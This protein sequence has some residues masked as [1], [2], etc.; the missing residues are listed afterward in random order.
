MKEFFKSL[1]VA[2]LVVWLYRMAYRG[3]QKIGGYDIDYDDNVDM[4]T[5]LTILIS[6]IGL[7]LIA[8]S[9]LSSKSSL[10][11]FVLL[12]HLIFIFL[13]VIFYLIKS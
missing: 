2:I 10:I 11:L 1:G 4:N 9:D 7:I 3:F 8:N 5:S 13:G 12:G 6:F